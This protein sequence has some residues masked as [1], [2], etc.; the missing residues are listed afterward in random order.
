MPRRTRI[1]LLLL[2][3]LAL[4]ACRNDFSVENRETPVHVGLHAPE[5]AA[6]GGSTHALV[7]VGAEKAVEGEVRFPPGVPN[8][9]LPPLYMP[10]GSNRT[11][12]VVLQGGEI[13]ATES[14]GIPAETWIQIT[15]RGREIEIKAYNGPPNCSR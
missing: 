12:S 9:A 11:V 13:S 6:T 10:G 15:I 1:A 2:A 8:I 5:L 7:Y 3:F 14:I 4:A